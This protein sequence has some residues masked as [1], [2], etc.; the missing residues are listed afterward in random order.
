MTQRAGQQHTPQCALEQWVVDLGDGGATVAMRLRGWLENL[1]GNAH[2]SVTLINNAAVLPQLPMPAATMLP[3]CC[4]SGWRAPMHAHYQHFCTPRP[5][6]QASGG[7]QHFRPVMAAARWHHSRC[8]AR[9]KRVWII[10]VAAWR[11]KGLRTS[12]AQNLL[13]GTRHH[14]DTDMQ[15]HLRGADASAFP[16][17]AR[18]CGVPQ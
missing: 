15:T 10:T 13:V 8:T 6:G 18:F 4:A 1:N 9:R 7:A 16:D 11:W 3:A 12:G 14:S 5:A 17:H 2:A